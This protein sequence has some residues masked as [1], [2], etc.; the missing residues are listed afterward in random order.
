MTQKELSLQMVTDEFYDSLA[1]AFLLQGAVCT[2]QIS[3]YLMVQTS[4][5]SSTDGRVQQIL[6]IECLHEWP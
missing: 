5:T 4:I 6:S 1:H 2:R 3:Q